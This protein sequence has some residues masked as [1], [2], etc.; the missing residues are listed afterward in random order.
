MVERGGIKTI[1]EKEGKKRNASNK[2]K[3]ETI[4]NERRKTVEKERM[5]IIKMKKN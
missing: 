5:K 2:R 4:K 3:N 1:K